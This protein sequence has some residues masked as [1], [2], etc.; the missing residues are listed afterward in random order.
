[1]LD[2]KSL[3]KYKEF[4]KTLIRDR[5]IKVG[6]PAMLAIA[7]I[8]GIRSGQIN[9]QA[10]GLANIL[11]DYGIMH[12]TDGTKGKGVYVITENYSVGSLGG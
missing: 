9:D 10:E 7:T 6:N 3:K 11:S 4:F 8:M 2:L 1:V 12:A 5:R